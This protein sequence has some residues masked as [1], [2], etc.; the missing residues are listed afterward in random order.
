MLEAGACG[1]PTLAA[2]LE[3]IRDVIREG[4]NGWLAAPGD[5]D[6]FCERIHALVNDRAQ[7][8]TVGGQASAYVSSAFS[9]EQSAERY[10]ELLRAPPPSGRL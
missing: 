8:R 2:D 1:L 9:W 5:A 7:L 6:A 10:L 4:V 3:G